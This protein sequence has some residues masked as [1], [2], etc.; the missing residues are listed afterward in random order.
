[1]RAR[2]DRRIG[3][4]GG[5]IASYLSRWRRER[6]RG[7]LEGLEPKKRGRASNLDKTPTDE[8]EQLRRENK[9]L[10]EQLAQ[11]ETINEV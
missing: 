9:R 6:D 2:G 7:Q 3:A 5:D 4:T 1:M 11:A 10:K 8:D